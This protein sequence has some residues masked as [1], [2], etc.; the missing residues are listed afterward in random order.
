VGRYS[1]PFFCAFHALAVDDSGGGAGL[2]PDLF[3]ALHIKHVMDI[4]QRAVI[5]PKIE[6][7]VERALGRKV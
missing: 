6:I 4:L 1:A 5:G 2:S 3:A 7:I